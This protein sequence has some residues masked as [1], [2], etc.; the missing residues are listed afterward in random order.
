LAAEDYNGV[1]LY[2][3]MTNLSVIHMSN[4]KNPSYK[5]LGVAWSKMFPGIAIATTL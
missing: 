4:F 5:F 3:I 1:N 2:K